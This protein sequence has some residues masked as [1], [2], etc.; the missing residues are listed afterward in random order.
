MPGFLL[1]GRTGS[2]YNFVEYYNIMNKN[3]LY[4]TFSTLQYFQQLNK[5]QILKYF[6]KQVLSKLY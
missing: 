5:H 1:G 4:L 2:Y 6:S 3:V